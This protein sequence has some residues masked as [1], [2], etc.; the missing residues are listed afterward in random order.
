MT[1][2]TEMT[3]ISRPT[4]GIRNMTMQ[5]MGRISID[6]NI[7]ERPRSHTGN[8]RLFIIRYHPH[9]GLNDRKQTLPGRNIMPGLNITL[10]NPPIMRSANFCPLQ[11][12]IR[13]SQSRLSAGKL[14]LLT[15]NHGLRVRNIRNNRRGN[16]HLRLSFR[17]LSTRRI[18]RGPG[19][20]NI[21]LRS[22]C[23]H[24]GMLSLI[25]R[26]RAKL[27]RF[28][29]GKLPLSGKE[30]TREVLLSDLKHHLI[31]SNGSFRLILRGCRLIT[32][33]LPVPGINPRQQLTGLYE[34][35]IVHQQFG[36]ISGNMR[37]NGNR[38][39]PRKRIACL[40]FKP[41]Q[42]PVN[43]A[44]DDHEDQNKDQN[45]PDKRMTLFSGRN[46]LTALRRGR[47]S[48][49]RR[50]GQFF[51]TPGARHQ[52]ADNTMAE[53]EIGNTGKIDLDQP[54]EGRQNTGGSLAGPYMLFQAYPPG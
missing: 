17:H 40:D 9:L 25:I 10:R 30:T 37:H 14:R 26:L 28:R 46:T 52:V 19:I 15:G 47:V 12:E 33:R 36:H 5:F 3:V 7:D 48:R 50:L 21:L 45:Q 32:I 22:R 49:I 16:L 31:G 18:K 24:N 43:H 39:S 38:T 11:I 29:G 8:L 2:R 6:L 35:V 51:C 4:I 20:I 34:L 53:F 44:P 13:Q 42:K 54:P 23:A 1:I 41:M 27:L